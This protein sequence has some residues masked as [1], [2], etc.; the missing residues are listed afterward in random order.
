MPKKVAFA[1]M[2][3]GVGKTTLSYMVC[4]SIYRTAKRPV[5]ILA[6]DL[7][8]QA[9]LSR[10]L[11]PDEAIPNLNEVNITNFFDKQTPLKN[12]VV[13]SK[14][15]N[16]WLIPSFIRLSFLEQKVLS[17]PLGTTTLAHGLK[18]IENEYELIVMDCPP[19]VG[20]FTLNGLMA[21]DYVICPVS[22]DFMALDGLKYMF[23]MLQQINLA[24]SNNKELGVVVNLVDKRYATH[25]YFIDVVQNNF[26]NVFPPLSRRVGIQRAHEIGE[27]PWQESGPGKNSLIQDM[28]TFLKAFIRFI[29]LGGINGKQ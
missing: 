24:T 28:T 27:S 13:S 21:A 12:C 8:P 2:K 6:V 10:K 20:A 18:E 19:N 4:T 22:P 3:G 29:N 9:N 16:V 23:S 15:D 14:F 1:N 11:V 17:S 25:K 5:K 26:K 7:D